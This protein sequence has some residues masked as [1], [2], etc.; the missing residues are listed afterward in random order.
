MSNLPHRGTR[1]RAAREQIGAS[2]ERLAAD[3]GVSVSTLVRL[4]NHDQLPNPEA[5]A[6]IV[7]AVGLSLDEL[8]VADRAAS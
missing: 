8:L 1:I 4:E 5:L 3:V 6:R 7:H 2:R